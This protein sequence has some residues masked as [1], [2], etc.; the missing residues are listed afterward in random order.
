[1]GGEQRTDPDFYVSIAS[2]AYTDKHPSV[3]FDEGHQNFHT[4]SGRYK[5][6]ADLMTNDGYLI[7]PNKETLTTQ[8]LTDR[9]VLVIA[10]ATGASETTT[11]AAGRPRVMRS[12]CTWTC[13]IP[14][15][16]GAGQYSLGQEP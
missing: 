14:S 5:V 6:F 10:N 2:P 8:R 16:P 12:T 7:M 15:R 9:D 11:S 1:M 13:Q 3:L 4:A